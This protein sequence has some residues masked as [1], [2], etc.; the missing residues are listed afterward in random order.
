MT[1]KSVS[2]SVVN[3]L[4]WQC[5]RGM[6][7]LDY[8]LEGYLDKHYEQASAEMQTAFTNLLTCEDPILQHWLLDGH[9]VE[10]AEFVEIVK[11]V[12]AI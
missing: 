4:R 8:M 1:E 5:R 7:E 10:E 3:R 6:L 12:R 9:T 2:E 11:A